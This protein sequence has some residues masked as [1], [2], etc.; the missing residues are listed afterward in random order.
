ML[1]N[2]LIGAGDTKYTMVVSMLTMFG[3]RIGMAYVLGQWLGL[4]LL[5]IWLAMQIDWIA[6][7][8]FF[9]GRFLRGKWKTIKV[10]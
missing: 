6:R 7:S 1:P 3:L 8:A 9:V 2:A 10:I 4:G 5:G